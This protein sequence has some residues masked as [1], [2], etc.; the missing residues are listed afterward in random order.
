M[1]LGYLGYAS[2]E[3]VQLLTN[4][5]GLNRVVNPLQSTAV[6][7]AGWYNAAQTTNY[8]DSQQHFEG[9]VNFELQAFPNLWNIIRDWLVED[10]VNAKSV[11]LSPNGVI[12]YDYTLDQND[13]RTGVWL[14]SAS[15]TVDKESIVTVGATCVGLRRTET[16]V[17]TT[18]KDLRDLS[19][20]NNRKPTAP[21]NPSPRNRNPIPG[22]NCRAEIS[23]PNSAPF[24]STSNLTGLV[25]MST[26]FNVNNQPVIIRGCTQD[27][28]P[29]A[30]L[31]GTMSVDGSMTLWRDGGIEDPYKT[32]D[33]FS[34]ENAN[35]SLH[36]GGG[37]PELTFEIPHVL[38]TSDAHDVQ[39]QNTE[40]VRTFGISG[41]GDGEN[42]PFLMQLAS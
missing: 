1:P 40:T 34:A 8:A 6:W 23:W 41:L 29:V 17:G 5:T 20:T 28:N 10:R 31:M 3:G 22:Y 7:G 13:P 26:N 36:I 19:D 30:V 35:L 14:G 16:V 12:Q 9:P 25:L 15:F 27:P 38:I 39:A 37:G 33:A 24:W 18:Y 21:L 2:I 42:P 4:T 11:S 32:Q